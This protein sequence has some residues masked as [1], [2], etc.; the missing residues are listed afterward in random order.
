MDTINRLSDLTTAYDTVNKRQAAFV[1]AMAKHHQA[2]NDPEMLDMYLRGVSGPVALHVKA[3]VGAVDV[4]S[5]LAP[6]RPMM[7]ALLAAVD[8]R[9]VLGQLGAMKVPS[10]NAVGAAATAT[11]SAY[12]VGEGNAKPVSALAFAALSL[13]PRKIAAQ[14]VLADELMR[15]A[16]DS[17]NLVERAT[18]SAAAAAIDS[19]LLDP[20][21]AGTAGVKPASLTNG[22]VTTPPALGSDFQTQVGH[23]LNAISGGSPTTPVLVVSLQ[24]ALRLSVLP[25]IANYVRVIVSPAASN[26]LIA[27]DADGIAYVDD[28]GELRIGTPDVQMDDSPT[29]PST[30]DTVMVSAW[31]RNL[32]VVKLERWVNWTKRADAVA[33]LELA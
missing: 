13:P 31:Q 25:N 7:Q 32:T 28:G 5:G 20:T 23:V 12:W 26:H 21:N 6:T 9:T 11:A 3:A 8:Q 14:V 24:T 18:V 27:I 33:I 1:T 2:H 29:N 10:M 19:A 16:T 4:S 15:V 22:V 30:A 17:V